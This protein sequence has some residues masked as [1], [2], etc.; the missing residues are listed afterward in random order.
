VFPS[1]AQRFFSPQIVTLVAALA[2]F[3]PR[4]AFAQSGPADSMAHALVRDAL[5]AYQSLEIDTAMDRLHDALRRC[6]RR[7]CSNRVLAEVQVAIGVVEV[8]G[9]ND[10][11]AGQ[12]AFQAALAADPGATVDPV[13]VTPDITIVFNRARRGNTPRP[14]QHL[15]HRPVQEQL[16]RS[17]TPIYVETGGN[18]AVRADLFYRRVGES[19]F[20]RIAM[21]RVAHGWGAT[22][23]CASVQRPAVEYY[24]WAYDQN[25]VP[26]AEAG[27]DESPLRIEVVSERTRPA[28]T[29]PGELAPAQCADTAPHGR[30]G[31]SCSDDEPCSQGFTCDAGTC[32]PSTP[33]PH[34]SE[35]LGPFPR[36][37]L[38]VGGGLGIGVLDG[39]VHYDEADM[40]V[41]PA[42]PEG[43]VRCRNGFSCPATVS[44]AGLTGFIFVGA[45][46]AIIPRLAIGL[47]ARFQPDS[48][49]RTVLAMMV[50]GLDGYYVFVGDQF[51][52]LGFSAMALAG[53]GV[54]QIQPRAPS[55]TA[56]MPMA[57]MGTG[58]IITGL[59]NVHF[60]AR[61][62]Y[63]F[64][65]SVHA[66]VELRFQFL[67]PQFYFDTDLQAT[68]GVHF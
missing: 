53:I 11:N 50:V 17:P 1:R 32:R 47:N 37:A 45:R 10:R 42:N 18:A 19:S 21:E 40:P 39:P 63:A 23:P 57:E 55:P 64:H 20:Q 65:S 9:H 61:L 66:G 6:G 68:I 5:D 56:A 28:P 60:G 24:V 4:S 16:V 41:D 13:L 38:D 48:G 46:I 44:G 8:G 58:H 30:D 67:W 43:D 12:R 49:P 59:Q 27:N 26:F 14:A 25:D 29:M 51:R 35:P 33:A 52:R 3:A 54:G 62:E 22:I 15:L 34:R 36:L 7:N 2:A 31:A